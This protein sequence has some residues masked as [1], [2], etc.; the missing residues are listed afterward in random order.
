[1]G[2]SGSATAPEG[3]GVLNPDGPGDE[4]YEESKTGGEEEVGIPMQGPAQPEE[5][6]VA[7]PPPRP[8]SRAIVTPA[9]TG[10]AMEVL[11]DGNEPAEE[12][13]FEEAEA[14]DEA[15]TPEEAHDELHALMAPQ[16]PPPPERTYNLGLLAERLGRTTFKWKLRGLLDD[17]LDEIEERSQRQ[18]T[19]AEVKAGVRG[20]V[21][22]QKRY[23]RLMIAYAT[24]YPNLEDQNLLAANGTVRAEDVVSRWLMAGE[25][26]LMTGAIQD[27]TGWSNNALQRAKG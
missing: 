12:E 9:E 19:K 22:D 5:P 17:E 10:G 2:E 20:T 26:D 21:K 27:L 11:D 16:P 14:S 8:V 13:D 6:A 15:L 25:I 4:A 18:P 24:V 23:Q 3:A 7:P 1:M